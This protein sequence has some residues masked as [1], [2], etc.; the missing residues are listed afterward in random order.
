MPKNSRPRKTST[1]PTRVYKYGLRPPT[2]NAELVDALF[3]QTRVHYNKLVT[4]ENIRRSRY[5]MARARLFPA[6]GALEKQWSKLEDEIELTRRSI[7]NTKSSSRTRSVPPSASQ[8]ITALKTRQKEITKQLQAMRP[9]TTRHPELV[10]VSKSASADARSAIKALR[11]DLYWGSYQLCER[12]LDQASKDSPFE[13]SYNDKPPHQ[14]KSRVGV[15]LQGGISVAELS[16]DTQL[17]IAPM[18]QFRTR[19]TGRVFARG[20][21]ARTTLRIRVDSTDKGRPVW[22]DFP[23]VMHRPLPPDSR[24]MGAYVTRQP[25]SVRIP[26]RYSL[27][28]SLESLLTDRQSSSTDQVGTTAINFG[29]RQIE[30]KLRVATVNPEGKTPFEIRLPRKIVGGHRFSNRLQGL[31]DDKLEE[32][33]KA[34]GAWIAE[35][36]TSLPPDFV[37]SFA[38]LSAWRSSHR[39]AE[40]AWYWRDHRVAGDQLIYAIVEQWRDRYRHLKDWLDHHR[41]HLLDWRLDYYR[42]IAKKI[43]CS[44]RRLVVD[45]FKISDVARRKKPEEVEEG[46]QQANTNRVIA[47]PG[48]LRRCIVGACTKYHCEILMAPSTNNTRRCNV[49]GD[50]YEWDPSRELVHECPGEG[51]VWDQD[52]NNTDNLLDHVASG[53]VVRLVTPASTVVD[54]QGCET[55]VAG[56]SRPMRDARDELSKLLKTK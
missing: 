37:A 27:C 13:I 34:L 32:V 23:M 44:N 15:Q 19:P 5:R 7:N 1:V 28:I 40:L 55:K 41:Q 22:A 14:C 35:N 9:E 31:V 29:W 18:P 30:G 45:D 26:W 51:A 11:K 17:Q 20:A 4:I 42:R 38:N 24:I 54:S 39:L 25:C 52:V 47:S 21:W 16:T 12:S 53:D 6:Y 43:A 36:E 48:E 3:A 10:E 8:G 50:L 49:C 33:K 56:S 2:E 46:G